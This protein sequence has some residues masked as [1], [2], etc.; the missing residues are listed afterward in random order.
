MPSADARWTSRSASAFDCAYGLR[1]SS[2]SSSVDGLA[3]SPYTDE[4]E[5]STNRGCRRAHAVSSRAVTVTFSRYVPASPGPNE[6]RTPG[7]PARCSTTSASAI[8]PRSSVARSHSVKVTPA[9]ASSAR[10][11]A[12]AAGDAFRPGASIARTSNPC[13]ISASTR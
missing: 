5:A 3:A 11:S 2:P 9:R 8:S 6:L 12:A 7:R 13:V 4:L 10:F 1:G